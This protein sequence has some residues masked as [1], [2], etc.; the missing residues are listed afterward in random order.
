MVSREFCLWL[1]TLPTADIRLCDVLVS[2]RKLETVP[3]SRVVG[4]LLGP[5]YDEHLVILQ[6]LGEESGYDELGAHREPAF[7]IQHG[8]KINDE[9]HGV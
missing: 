5:V 1:A 6:H 3:V 9:I 8:A 7:R 2:A 4:E